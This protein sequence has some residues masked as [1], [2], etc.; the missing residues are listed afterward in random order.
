MNIII[1]NRIELND[2]L[3]E[4]NIILYGAG[5]V[6]KVLLFNIFQNPDN[7]HKIFCIAVSELEIKK[8]PDNILGVPVCSIVN[9]GKFTE[10]PIIISTL[11]KLHK[12]IYDTLLKQGFQNIYSLSNLV[13]AELRKNNPQFAFEI[14]QYM[15]SIENRMNTMLK[16]LNHMENMLKHMEIC[17]QYGV[18]NYEEI[19][20]QNEYEEE[21]KKWYQYRSGKELDLKHPIT[22]NEK[23]QWIKLYGITPLIEKLSDK[24]EVRDWVA[25]KIG[26]E[27]L[28]PIYGIWDQFDK[29][30]FD[31][32]P[33]KMVLKC[34]HGSG[35]NIVINNNFNKSEARRYF[36]QWMNM[37]FAF[38]H[39]FE[40]QYKNIH[41]RIIAEEYLENKN[42][43]L[44]DYKFW[45]FHGKVQ[46][47]MFLSERGSSLKMNNYDK[48]WNLLPFV[49]NYPNSKKNYSRPIMLEK[50]IKIAEKLSEEF[51]FVR[52][53]LYQLNDGTIKF[54]E[55]TFTP[56]SGMCGWNDQNI[57][58]KLGQL[59]H[60]DVEE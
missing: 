1:K 8:N 16:Q 14:L 22:F 55:M 3:K 10:Y 17:R 33:K 18:K 38:M 11:E 29:I 58:Y 48:N 9:L 53:D 45:C 15:Q 56:A 54:G 41:P 31:E 24:W 39:G 51:H 27:Y 57:N 30:D 19:L 50:M 20:L 5:L 43:D 44:Y 35:W 13:Y 46:F 40:L 2:V 36:E 12:P 34:T 47:I 59:I 32:L 6:A 49:Y 26:E 60:L 4:E 42:G 21:L 52:V 25:Q 7:I 37:N 28:I 23:I